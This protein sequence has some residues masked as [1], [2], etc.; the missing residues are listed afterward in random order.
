M[1]GRYTTRATSHSIL[2]LYL[3]LIIIYVL[4]RTLHHKLDIP[5]VQ[6]FQ[7]NHVD[8]FIM[9]KI[10]HDPPI[11]FIVVNPSEKVSLFLRYTLFTVT[12]SALEAILGSAFP[13]RISDL[14]LE[15]SPRSAFHTPLC[16]GSMPS[17]RS[18]PSGVRPSSHAAGIGDVPD[19]PCNPFRFPVP[20]GVECIQHLVEKD[21]LS[22]YPFLSGFVDSLP[23][24]RLEV[25]SDVIPS[26]P[27][28]PPSLYARGHLR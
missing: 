4:C 1:I 9:M 26:S 3:N 24:T 14:S 27:T 2:I 10:I 18:C 28:I 21:L 13:L 5:Y 25:F 8:F 15:C 6:L 22:E 7:M 11:D 16:Q 17:V 19:I 12:M 23:H 20:C